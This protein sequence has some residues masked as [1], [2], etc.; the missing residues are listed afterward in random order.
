MFDFS[1]Q[2]HLYIFLY[3]FDMVFYVKLYGKGY[4]KIYH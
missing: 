1:V 3:Q 2:R 4:L